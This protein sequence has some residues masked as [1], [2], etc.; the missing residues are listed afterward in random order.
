MNT[1]PMILWPGIYDLPIDAYHAHPSISK[2]GLDLISASPWRYFKRKL[3]KGRPPEV[4]KAGQL[5][6]QLAHC[7]ILEPD[8]FDRRYVVVPDD[9]PT[10]PSKRLRN[11]ATKSFSTQAS[12]DW[13]DAFEAEHGLKRSISADQR[14][15]ALRQADSI[16]DLPDIEYVLVGG[17]AEQSAFWLDPDTSELC[18]VRPDWNKPVGESEAILLDIKTFSDISPWAFSVQ[19]ARKRYHVQE[20]MYS[21]GWKVTTGR[22]VTAFIF[23]VVEDTY[24]FDSEMFYLNAA[25]QHRGRELYLSD[26]K[27]YASCKKSGVWPRKST[28]PVEIS[29]PN[30]ALED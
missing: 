26:L 17:R 13:W 2:S 1:T 24:P 19:V 4:E 5:E 9:A 23:V 25:S 14:E 12:I 3:E 11:A 10:K 21:D 6:G 18:R 30:Y 20:A 15:T 16:R 28:G 8:E 29:L 7:A 27:M 22:D